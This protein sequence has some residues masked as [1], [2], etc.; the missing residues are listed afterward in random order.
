[1]V[2]RTSIFQ[3]KNPYFFTVNYLVDIF[4]VEKFHVLISKL[5]KHS[6]SVRYRNIYPMDNSP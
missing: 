3:I 5:N 6:F 1:M 2:T 4:V